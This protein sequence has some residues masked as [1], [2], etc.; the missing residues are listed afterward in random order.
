MPRVARKRSEADIY[1]VI[2]RGAG[3]RILFESDDDRR[4]FL[5]ML[6]AALERAGGRALA[7]CLMSNHVHMLLKVDF[8]AL[9][10]MMQSLTSGYA[11]YYNKEHGHVGH[12]FAGR[13]NSVPVD[14]D[15]YLMTVVR[16]IHFNPVKDG[17]APTCAYRWS[18]Y[19]DYVGPGA[20]AVGESA[21]N[22]ATGAVAGEGGT[23]IGSIAGEGGFTETGFVLDAFGGLRQ[24]VDF[25]RVGADDE[26]GALP[27]LESAGRRH[28]DR[29]ALEVARRVLGEQGLSELAELDRAQRNEKIALLKRSGLTTRQIERFTGIGR[30]IIDRVKWR[31]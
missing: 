13:F 23:A 8:E 17:L 4:T 12:V 31:E 2:V 15:E 9:S 30:G 6:Q 7:W 5:R 26:L 21:G 18:S 25:H 27:E 11:V 28:D 14:S 20:G 19:G 16:Y 22:G 1:H 24:F 29:E 3:R 10:R